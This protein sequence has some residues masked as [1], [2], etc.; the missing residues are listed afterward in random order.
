MSDL[1][2]LLAVGVAA[3]AAIL[4]VARPLLRSTVERTD[5]LSD[6]QRRRLALREERDAALL[7]LRDLEFDHRTG[8]ITD[9]DYR[10]MVREH[11]RRVADALQALDPAVAAAEPGPAPEAETA[12][13]ERAPRA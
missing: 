8:K 12:A 6:E 1:V 2:A 9:E 4:L 3:A 11:R 13:P 10:P 7:A 5:Q